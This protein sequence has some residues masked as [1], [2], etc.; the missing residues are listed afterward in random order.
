MCMCTCV[1]ANLPFF[2]S[3]AGVGVVVGIDVVGLESVD[4]DTHIIIHRYDQY[5]L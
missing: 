1:H 3:D 4:G 5:C 2:A